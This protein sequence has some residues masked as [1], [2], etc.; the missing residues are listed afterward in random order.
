MKNNEIT[1][2]KKPIPVKA[3]QTTKKINIK[4]L[5]GVMTA[6]PGDWIITGTEGEQWPVRQDIF[7]KNYKKI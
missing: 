2:V 5:E 4:T 6:N 3:V 1:V 7:E